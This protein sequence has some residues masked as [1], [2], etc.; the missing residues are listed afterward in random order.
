MAEGGALD[1]DAVA[2]E[3]LTRLPGVDDASLLAVADSFRGAEGQKR[4]EMLF[5]R[6]AD[7]VRSLATAAAE[8]GASAEIDRWARAWE[9]LIALPRDVEAV[10][11]DRADA[12]FTAVGRLKQAARA[13]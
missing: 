3:I 6:L 4:F 2:R 9:A 10:N 7:Q 13:A 1:A 5:D 8:E 11:L 12:F